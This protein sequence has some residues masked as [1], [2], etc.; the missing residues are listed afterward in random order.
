MDDLWK[1]LF[2]GR[3][4]WLDAVARLAE[5]SGSVQMRELRGAFV[6]PTRRLYA[7]PAILERC[8]LC[9]SGGLAGVSG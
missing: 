7:L 6:D 4:G 1:G 2:A 8:L 9:R 5:L 3:K